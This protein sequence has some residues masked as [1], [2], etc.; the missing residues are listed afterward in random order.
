MNQAGQSSSVDGSRVAVL[1]RV[2]RLS[3][4]VDLAVLAA[5]RIL[6]A[7]SGDDA[8]ADE[9]YVLVVDLSEVSFIDCSGL[10]PLLETE[11]RLGR[12]LRLQ[13][14]SVA[15]IRLLQLADLV[16]HFR[17]T[18]DGGPVLSNATQG[19]SRMGRVIA[20]GWVGP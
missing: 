7:P 15:V 8:E 1:R 3:G 2:E 6:L 4:P 19:A 18:E 12:R 5:T 14:C 20:E 11:A 17:Y 16:R 9:A 13:H 10:R